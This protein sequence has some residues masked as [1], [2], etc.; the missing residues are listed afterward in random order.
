[1]PCTAHAANAADRYRAKVEDIHN[2]LK[3]D[4]GVEREAIALELIDHTLVQPTPQP[5]PVGLE[6]AGNLAGLLIENPPGT[7]VAESLVAGARFGQNCN[8]ARQTV[9]SFGRWDNMPGFMMV[10]VTACQLRGGATSH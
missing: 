2:A 9:Y 4:N 5:D 10:P 6:V 7:K 8:D 3:R 1:M